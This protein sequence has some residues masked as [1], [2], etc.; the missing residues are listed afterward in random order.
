MCR[1]RCFQRPYKHVM[2]NMVNAHIIYAE[3]EKVTITVNLPK[4]KTIHR[5]CVFLGMVNHIGEFA[6]HPASKTKPI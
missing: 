5:V 6:E 1:N 2:G 3:T 4:P